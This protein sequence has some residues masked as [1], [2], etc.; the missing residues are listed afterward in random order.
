MHIT[1]QRGTCR[2]DMPVIS[3]F[4]PVMNSLVGQPEW[5]KTVPNV[6]RRGMPATKICRTAC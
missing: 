6:V 2:L 4:Q 5:L 1:P 3:L